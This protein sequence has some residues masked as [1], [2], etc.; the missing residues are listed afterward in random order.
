VLN[1]SRNNRLSATLLA[2]ALSLL[3]SQWSFAAPGNGVKEDPSA[4]AMTADLLFVRPAMFTVTVVGSAVWLLGL[5]FSAAGGNVKGSAETLVVGPAKNT[6][7]RCLGCTKDGYQA[8]I[9]ER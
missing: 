6:F 9:E 2:V 7:V 1:V 5:P 4:F 8:T 3:V